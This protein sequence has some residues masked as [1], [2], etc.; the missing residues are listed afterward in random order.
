MRTKLNHIDATKIPDRLSSACHQLWGHPRPST[1]SLQL[2][3]LQRLLVS[4]GKSGFDAFLRDGEGADREWP[5]RAKD[6]EAY[7]RR[8]LVHEVERVVVLETLPGGPGLGHL[9]ECRVGKVPQPARERL[10][11][12]TLVVRKHHGNVRRALLQRALDG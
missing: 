9:G 12:E 11:T 7:T 8:G 10:K 3:L 5:D 2:R 4:Q 1:F 6:P